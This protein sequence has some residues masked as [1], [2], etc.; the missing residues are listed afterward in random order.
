MSRGGCPMHC[1][2]FVS[3]DLSPMSAQKS[4]LGLSRC[5]GPGECLHSFILPKST[6]N[7]R[8][9][10]QAPAYLDT[11]VS[12]I[13]VL[14]PSLRLSLH[15]KKLPLVKTPVP[16]VGVDA[17]VPCMWVM[18]AGCWVGCGCGCCVFLLADGLGSATAMVTNVPCSQH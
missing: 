18:G 8:V 10:C 16:C 6:R 2:V 15:L 11:D 1:S 17:A 14:W 9:L 13:P 12:V 3:G 7:S 4:G 5:I